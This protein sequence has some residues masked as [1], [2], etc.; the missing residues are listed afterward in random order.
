MLSVR[1]VWALTVLVTVSLVSKSARSPTPQQH[2]AAQWP[3]PCGKPTCLLRHRASRGTPPPFPPCVLNATAETGEDLQR[4]AVWAQ[5][6]AFEA[7]LV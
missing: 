4:L 5:A 1:M 2:G 7:L 3:P 6:E